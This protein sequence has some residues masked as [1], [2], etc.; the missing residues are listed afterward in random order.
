[1]LRALAFTLGVTASIVTAQDIPDPDYVFASDLLAQAPDGE[2]LLAACPAEIYATRR[3]LN[4]LIFGWSAYET[5]AECAADFRS[6]VESCH[7]DMDA[8]ACFHT[9]VLLERNG[10][11]AH[12]LSSQ[13]GYAV[14]CAGGVPSGCTNRG[15]G[16]R[17]AP[18]IGDALSRAPWDDKL[19]CLS[20]TFASSCKEDDS[21]G[22]AM[23]GQSYANGEGVEAD[24]ARALVLFERACTL[25]S[26]EDFPSCRFARARIDALQ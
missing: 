7:E 6:C 11:A 26:N 2:A 18:T 3:T 1:M 25:A 23:S 9:S 5:H 12:N 16:I 13:I 22:C 4:D 14:A 24:T 8:R 21:W 15:A 20:E 10:L 17:N 19:D